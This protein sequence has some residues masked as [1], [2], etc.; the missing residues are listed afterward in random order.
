MRSLMRIGVSAGLAAILLFG[1]G[2]SGE[3]P[4]PNTQQPAKA[5]AS[6]PAATSAATRVP[7]AAPTSAAPAEPKKMAPAPPPTETVNIPSGTALTVVM[8]DA[9]G[10]DS[11]KPGDT[12]TGSLGEPVVV[13]G[14]TV[15]A[16][17]TKVRGRVETVTEPGRV[18]GKA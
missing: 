9:V 2:Q 16:K 18:Q 7:A 15:I 3:T 10:T 8:I 17:G 11:S 14:K 12:F 5:E 13:N 4:P 1:C 6:T